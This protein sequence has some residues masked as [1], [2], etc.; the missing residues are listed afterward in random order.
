[1]LYLIYEGTDRAGKTSTRKL[2]EKYR[3]GKDVVIDRF[4]GSNIVFGKVF[5]R[6]NDSEIKKLYDDER[7]FA[8]MY[9][10]VLIYLYSSSDVILKRIKKDN[11]EKIDKEIIEKTLEEYN[12][13]FD[14]SYIKN[15][16]K[17]NTEKFNQDEVVKI[18]I[19]YLAAYNNK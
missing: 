12:I 7:N 1:M 19:N 14:N 17:I 2:V 4:I 3:K 18:I 16:I 5:E 15:K 8:S 11:H 9:E 10:P 13:Y 6:Y